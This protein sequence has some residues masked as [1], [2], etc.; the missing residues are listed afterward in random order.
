[1]RSRPEPLAGVERDEAIEELRVPR[2]DARESVAH[3]GPMRREQQELIERPRYEQDPLARSRIALD[4]R[5]AR[6]RLDER[7]RREQP[8]A[9]PL[10]RERIEAPDRVPDQSDAAA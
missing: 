7:V 9:D 2:D 3:R 5:A 10:A 8:H 4:R 1:M 6:D